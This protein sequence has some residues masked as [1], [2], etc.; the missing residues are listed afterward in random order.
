MCRR[1]IIAAQMTFSHFYWTV[2]V[3]ICSLHFTRISFADGIS[4]AINRYHSICIHISCEHRFSINMSKITE[5]TRNHIH[6][7]PFTIE[8]LTHVEWF[9]L[10]LDYF[11]KLLLLLIPLVL[12]LHRYFSFTH[13]VISHTHRKAAIK[14]NQFRN[15]KI[16]LKLFS[17]V[18]K[19]INSHTTTTKCCHL[20]LY[21]LN[22]SQWLLTICYTH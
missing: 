5:H 8:S 7:T 3:V 12:S 20:L 9:S 15:P 13:R 4:A 17:C 19:H 18:A 1:T 10:W 11:I 21:G 22:G 6:Y 16:T 2:F 14:R